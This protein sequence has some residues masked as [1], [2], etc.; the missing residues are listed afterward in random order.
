MIAFDLKQMNAACSMTLSDNSVKSTGTRIF[1]L[2]MSWCF[3][4][5]IKLFMTELNDFLITWPKNIGKNNNI[6]Y[7]LL[8]LVLSIYQALMKI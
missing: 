3:Y 7:N 6:Q 8:R 1:L 2:G 5:R 4:V